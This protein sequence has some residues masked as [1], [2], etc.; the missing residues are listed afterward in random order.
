M[1]SISI[2]ME[3]LAVQ[4]TFGK[5]MKLTAPQHM[6][7]PLILQAGGCPPHR[8][9]EMTWDN[10]NYSTEVISI[11]WRLFAPCLATCDFYLVM[12]LT[13]SSSLFSGGPKFF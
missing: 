12:A 5:S 6:P 13:P 4:F 11:E 1:V 3:F 7:A 10:G 2:A 9:P 8:L